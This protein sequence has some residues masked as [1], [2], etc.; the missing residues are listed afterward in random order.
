MRTLAI[1]TSVTVLGCIAL[2]ADQPLDRALDSLSSVHRFRDV[3]LSMDGATVAWVDIGRSDGPGQASVYVKDLRASGSA[4]RIAAAASS[5]HALAWSHDGRL[6]FLS[7]AESGDQLQLYVAA[8]AGRG[9]PRKVTDLKGYINSPQWSPD[10]RTIALLWIQGLTRVP[11]PTEATPADTGVISSQV[12]EQR[13]AL[14]D[15]ATG[16]VRA[17]S[18]SNMY[19]YEFDW[20][21]NG[22]QLAYLAAPGAGDDNWYL[23]ELYAIDS[24]SGLVKHILKP[25]VQVANVRWSPDGKSLA[26]IG[27][28]MSDEGSTG[29]DIFV[30][31]A[32]GGIPRNLTPNR[33]SSPNWFRWM[34]SSQQILMTEDSS[35]QMAVSTLDLP[36]GSVEQIWKGAETIEFSGDATV[37]AVIRSSWAHAPEIWAGRTGAWQQLTN[38]NEK[39][40][41]KWGT[42]RSIEWNSDSFRVQGWLLAPQP[43]DPSKRYPMIVVVHGGPAADTRSSWPRPG[44]PLQ[45]LSSQGYFLFYPNPRGSYGQGEEFTQANVKDFGHGDLRDILA[46]VDTVAKEYPIDQN[47]MGIAGW[48]Y[49]GYMTMWT[50]T[51]THRFRAAFAG[52]GIA[53]WQSYYGENAIDQWMIPYFGASV[54]DD[55]AVYAKSSP[56]NFIKNVTTPTLIAVGERDGECP[57]PQSYEFWH[58]LKTLGVKTEFVLYPGEGHT[59]HD[60]EHS[61][62][63]FTRIV[64]WFQDNM[65]ASAVQ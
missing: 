1:A 50:V 42:A 58:A 25:A 6:A 12:Y 43:Y 9:T 56:I 3:A 7:N 8:S 5:E 46:G 57:P 44:L 34:P 64:N 53:N 49:G 65:P 54:Y 40:Q 62:D 59:F 28:I 33:K 36:S 15:V 29:G 20:S 31:P 60:P 55:P 30:L 2:R 39:V 48:S 45:L 16:A 21:P 52:A 17:L 22:K 37:S 10:G 27:G 26:F 35:G 4:R 14:V 18:P 23:A 24:A 47:R 61:R 63:V 41:P 11:G 51:Q 19:V 32:A 38:Q 13:L